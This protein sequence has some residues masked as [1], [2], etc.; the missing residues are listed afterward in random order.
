M[1][2]KE[3][4]DDVRVADRQR[5]IERAER[6]E[7]RADLD[8]VFDDADPSALDDLAQLDV[9]PFTLWGV[10]AFGR[11]ALLAHRADAER[12]KRETDK[13][14]EMRLRRQ[15]VWITQDHAEHW[16]N[17]PRPARRGNP[18]ATIKAAI[19]ADLIAIGVRDRDLREYLIAL[20]AVPGPY[21][22]PVVVIVEDP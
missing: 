13:A 6:S 11:E 21:S 18:E 5:M 22:A 4:T 12:R 17:A 8:L 20:A 3:R 14:D 10:V 9:D 19:R 1:R 2:Y 7:R 16:R 15:G